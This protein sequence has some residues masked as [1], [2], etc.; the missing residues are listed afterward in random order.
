MSK[1]VTDLA[2]VLGADG[3]EAV[4]VAY[5]QPEPRGN[6]VLTRTEHFIPKSGWFTA[7]IEEAYEAAIELAEMALEAA[8]TEVEEAEEQD[9]E[10]D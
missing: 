2:F 7:L 1:R 3:V 8:P 10:D 9:D 4:T 5:T 6:G